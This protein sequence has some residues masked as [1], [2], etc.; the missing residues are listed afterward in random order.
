MKKILAMILAAMMLCLVFVACDKE[1]AIEQPTALPTT[2]EPTEAPTTE[3]PTTEEITTDD[4]L[5]DLTDVYVD[6]WDVDDDTHTAQKIETTSK[7]VGICVTIPEGG[8]LYEAAVQAPSYSDNI[9]N[10]TIKVFAWNTDFATT[11]AAEPL[12]AQEFVD[13][14]DNSDLVCEFDE[15]QIPA[16]TY[17]ILACDAVDESDS[18]VGLWMGKTYKTAN[19]PEEYVKYDIQSWI[20]G[21]NNKKTIAKFSLTITEPEE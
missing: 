13:F 12:Y 3:E 14:A 15:G 4:G 7:G 11:I 18:G 1:P 2:E 10:L 17:L 9:G 5:P 6:V 16:G 20:N 8:Y 21:K 19:L